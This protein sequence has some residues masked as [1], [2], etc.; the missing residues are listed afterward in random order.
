[1][2][3]ESGFTLLEVL[4]ALTIMAVGV[5]LTMSVISGS[6]KNLR[7]ARGAEA[8]VEHAQAAL[9]VA[10]LDDSIQGSTSRQG[11]F[12]DGTRWL[13]QVTEIE[14]PAPPSSLPMSPQ[15]TAPKLLEFAVAVT[16]P[17]SMTADFQLH[18]LKM[19]TPLPAVQ[20]GRSTK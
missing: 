1:V 8:L 16:G 19:I 20:G 13:V 18:T 2:K 6:L 12:E 15:I 17:H 9:E 14:M 11:D 7:K 10:L 3:R 4:M 5:A